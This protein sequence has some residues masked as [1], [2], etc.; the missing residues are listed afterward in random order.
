[1]IH[2]DRCPLSDSQL[3]YIADRIAVKLL[4]FEQIAAVSRRH[5]VPLRMTVPEFACA[6]HLGQEAIRQHIR[7]RFIPREHVE[8]RARYFIDRAALGKYRVTL[9]VADERLQGWREMSPP[10]QP[11]QPSGL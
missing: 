1:M 2:E 6:V 8:G 7:S 3:D 4:G 10:A 5:K 11:P 9:E